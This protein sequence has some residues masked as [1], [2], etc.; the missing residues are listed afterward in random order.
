M[1]YDSTLKAFVRQDIINSS[2]FG[3]LLDAGLLAV[4]Q[5]RAIHSYM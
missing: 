2:V 1:M 5:A 4:L 3:Q